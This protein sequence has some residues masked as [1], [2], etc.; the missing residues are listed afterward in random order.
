M[1]RFFNY[2]AVIGIGCCGRPNGAVN[3]PEFLRPSSTLKQ[4][5]L[6]ERHRPEITVRLAHPDSA[7]TLA[8]MPDWRCASRLQRDLG[9]EGTL[10]LLFQMGV[11]VDDLIQLI[12]KEQSNV[13][14]IKFESVGPSAGGNNLLSQFS[15]DHSTQAGTTINNCA[16]GLGIGQTESVHGLQFFAVARQLPPRI[17]RSTCFRPNRL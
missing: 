10:A 11:A 4:H 3:R 7:A 17:P 1:P 15:W 8:L 2:L 6:P 9:L 16:F 13:F 14:R 5:L 12:D